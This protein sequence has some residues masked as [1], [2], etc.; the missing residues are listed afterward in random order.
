MQTLTLN[1]L[2]SAM[3]DLNPFSVIFKVEDSEGRGIHIVV[4]CSSICF[5]F[6]QDVFCFFLNGRYSFRDREGWNLECRL[7]T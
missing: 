6:L 3:K 7:S 4:L 5:V 2:T 1:Y